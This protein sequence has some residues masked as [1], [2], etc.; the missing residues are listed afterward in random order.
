MPVT[1]DQVTNDLTNLHDGRDAF[2]ANDNALAAAL[3]AVET[4]LAQHKTDGHTGIPDAVQA[5][6]DAKQNSFTFVFSF[7]PG[8][9]KPTI[10][11]TA[12][13]SQVGPS[14]PK[15]GWLLSISVTTTAGGTNAATG[16]FA[17]PAGAKISF[18]QDAGVCSCRLNGTMAP[19]A[20]YS[21][22]DLAFATVYGV[23]E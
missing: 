22:D 13:T 4:D 16:S 7:A 17:F 19:F 18:D 23:Y 5:A 20:A 14:L 3:A 10:G 1:I 6:L 9:T 21:D 15:S 8:S 11:G 2:I 12:V